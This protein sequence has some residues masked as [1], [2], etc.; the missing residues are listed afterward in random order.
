MMLRLG[1]AAVVDP[2]IVGHDQLLFLGDAFM[3]GASPGLI[4]SGVAV[5]FVVSTGRDSGVACSVVIAGMHP[6]RAGGLIRTSDKRL[7]TAARAR[8][9]QG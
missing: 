4:C 7:S 9:T 5:D 2:D 8:S 6:G 3:L 1:A